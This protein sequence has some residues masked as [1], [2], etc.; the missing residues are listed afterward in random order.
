MSSNNKFTLDDIR[1]ELETKYAPFELTMGEETF[2]LPSLLRVDKAVRE[3]VKDI[4]K[5]MGGETNEA[6]EVVL[7]GEDQDEDF[8]VE[9]I[10]E[11][12][13]LVTANDRGYALKEALPDDMLLVMEVLKKWQEVTQAG[14]A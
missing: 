8:L 4:F 2:V 6:G 5:E 11:V 3:Q 10:K 13:G 9:Q 14:E 7:N 12:L 1:R